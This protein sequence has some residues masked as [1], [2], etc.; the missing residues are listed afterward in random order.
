[1]KLAFFGPSGAGKTT[2][3]NKLLYKFSYIKSYTTRLPR[4]IGDDEYIFIS[5][6]R[7]ITLMNEG[8]FFEYENI[9]DNYYGTS[10]ESLVTENAIFNVNID[11]MKK[12]QSKI[13]DLICIM[14]IPPSYDEVRSRITNRNCK[15]IEKRLA[16]IV[17]DMGG[18]YHYAIVNDDLD[19]AYR[20]LESICDIESEKERVERIK[21]SFI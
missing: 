10:Y 20:I 7:F 5:K 4:G 11:G 13:K 12:L 14:I 1:M 18:F 8:F 16:N 6:D 19:R 3:I 21:S 9:F 2:L 17:Y 15:D